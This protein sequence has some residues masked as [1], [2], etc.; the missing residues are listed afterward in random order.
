MAKKTLTSEQITQVTKE[1]DTISK[2]KYLSPEKREECLQDLFD[3]L[4][5]KKTTTTNSGKPEKKMEFKEKK[6]RKTTVYWDIDFPPSDR[7]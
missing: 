7:L 5:W 1:I 2:L 4:E 6:P 3:I